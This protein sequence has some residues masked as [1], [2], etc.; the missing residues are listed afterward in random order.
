MPEP[1]EQGKE[2]T[3]TLFPL[4]I[5]KTMGETMTHIPKGTFKKD[6]HNMNMRVT[7]NTF[8]VEDLA[9]NACA[10][11]S[12]E[13]LQSFPSQK[14]DFLSALGSVETCNPREIVLDPT[15]LKPRLPYHVAFHIV[16]AYTTKSFTQNISRTV[17]DEGAL[18]CMMLL[19]CWKAIGKP[20][21]SPSPTFL[22]T[23]DGHSFKPH[24]IIPYFPMQLGGKTVCVKFE[25]V[26]V[27]LDY[28]LLLGRIWNYEIHAV[29]ATFFQLL[30][31]PYEGRI[32]TID[33]LS[34]FHPDPSLGA[35]TLP[36]IDNP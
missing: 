30:L 34:F 12:W 5:E 6:Y 11:S 21:L 10:M 26:D 15:D 16:V 19:A 3:N 24:G 8:V 2:A 27:P 28:N 31:F 23:F 20:I 29:V 36:M 17:V 13:V 7:Q 33:Q 25:V 9:Q 35:S 14:K 22:T 4:Q 32:V 1:S 18:T